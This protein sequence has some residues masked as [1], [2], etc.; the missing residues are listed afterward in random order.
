MLPPTQIGTG[1]CTGFGS[2]PTG[3]NV[4]ERAVVARVGVGEQLLEHLELLVAALAAV[5]VGH[6]EHVELLLHPPHADAEDEAT[7][8]HHVE[9]G[10][11]L[12]RQDRRPVRR[13]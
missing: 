1:A 3:G 9:R 11:R 7:A 2:K 13:G 10:H 5:V 4:V 8:R 12:G 6:A